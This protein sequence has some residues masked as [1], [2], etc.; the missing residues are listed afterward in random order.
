M[1][2]GSHLDSNQETTSAS[3]HIIP[4]NPFLFVRSPKHLY[5]RNRRAKKPSLCISQIDFCNRK[6]Q[7]HALRNLTPTYNC[8]PYTNLSTGIVP[9]SL[10]KGHV[11]RNKRFG[12]WAC[13]PLQQLTLFPALCDN[14][15]LKCTMYTLSTL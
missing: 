9:K 14:T 11:K 12:S 13:T 10:E 3:K 8:L 7:R 15:Y 5:N 4:R 6:F 2:S 1:A